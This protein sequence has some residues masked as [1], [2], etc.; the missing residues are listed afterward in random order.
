MIEFMLRVLNYLN[1]QS[2]RESLP[3]IVFQAFPFDFIF[4]YNH[5]LGMQYSGNKNTRERYREFE[6]KHY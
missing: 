2:T 3:S 5:K 6:V 4:L 1:G